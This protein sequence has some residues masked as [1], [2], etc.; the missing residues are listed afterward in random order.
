MPKCTR[1]IHIWKN[2]TDRKEDFPEGMYVRCGK[3]LACKQTRAIDKAVRILN[4]YETYNENEG[5]Y[6]LYF[7]TFTYDDEHIYKKNGKLSLNKKHIRKVRDKIYSRM[8]RKYY[9][10]GKIDRSLINYKY[11]IAGE[12]GENGTN[13]PHYHMILL[14]RGHHNEIK[15]NW[16]KE[17][18]GGRTDVQEGTASAIFYTAKYTAKKLGA[19]RK[20]EDIEDAFLICSK[21]LGKEWAIR[22]S[23]ELKGREYILVPTK[24][25]VFKKAIFD[26]YLTWLVKANLWTEEEVEDLKR[27]KREFIQEQEDKI[28]EKVVIE[29]YE[30]LTRKDFDKNRNERIKWN[31]GIELKDENTDIYLNYHE[32]KSNRWYNTLYEEYKFK[33]NRKR[34]KLLYKKMVEQKLKRGNKIC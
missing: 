20:D 4:E 29:E 31:R 21:G 22:H 17:L 6:K 24:S 27:R 19:D 13:R 18:K 32:A 7:L 2:L 15:N 10:G 3:C 25:G 5:K 14:T 28:I 9:R 8:Y 26:I 11:M 30:K 12:Y 34:A 23:E 16:I 1:P 33:I